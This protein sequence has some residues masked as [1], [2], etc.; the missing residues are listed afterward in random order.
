MRLKTYIVLG[1]AVLLGNLIA[2]MDSRP[3]WDDTGITAGTIL[4]V[5][6]IATVVQPKRPWLTA[7]CVGA[8]VPIWDFVIHHN[9]GSIIALAIAFVGAY[10]GFFVRKLMGFASNGAEG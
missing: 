10:A 6:A 1:F 5:S 2:W 7:L 8:W 9:Y 4:L 3:G